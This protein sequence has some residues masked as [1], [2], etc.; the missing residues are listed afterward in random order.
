M[1]EFGGERPRI[2]LK[3]NQAV[4]AQAAKEIPDQQSQAADA[5][6]ARHYNLATLAERQAQRERYAANLEDRF[7]RGEEPRVRRNLYVESDRTWVNQLNSLVG[8]QRLFACVVASLR[9]VLRQSGI[10][11]E[12]RDSEVQMVQEVRDLFEAAGVQTDAA[13]ARLAGNRR[14]RGVQVDVANFQQAAE[15]LLDG[16]GVMHG[17]GA[18]MVFLHRV[19][20]RQVDQSG[21]P[22]LGVNRVDPFAPVVRSEFLPLRDLAKEDPFYRVISIAPPAGKPRLVL[23][24]R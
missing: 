1:S 5:R 4:P 21:Q 22:T 7:R 24:P 20:A 6:P 2:I 8:D 11:D 17:N 19:T 12:T 15:A 3:R 18:H 16:R 14:D 10:Y 9:N 23:K 13:L